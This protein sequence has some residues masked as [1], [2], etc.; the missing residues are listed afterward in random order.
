MDINV[1]IDGKEVEVNS[2]QINLK[3]TV[4]P[5]SIG[6]PSDVLDLSNWKL[7]L[8]IN[9]AKE[10]LQ[11]ELKTT[12]I[13]PYFTLNTEKTAVQF[14]AP[15]G[16]DTTSNSSYPR[17]ELRE[18]NGS[19]KASWSTT[20]GKHTLVTKQ[21]ITSFPPIKPQVV[22]AQIHD[23]KDDI[24][25]VLYDGKRGNPGAIAVRFNGKT[26]NTL[27][28]DTYQIGTI[29]ALKIEAANGYI[30]IYYNDIKKLF[31]AKVG[32]KM[33]FK[34]GCY[35]QSNVSNPACNEAPP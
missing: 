21:A 6:F 4:Q 9:I 13:E 23:D 35:T 20:S 10:I 2:L 7:T 11:P 27:L 30:N 29:F 18:M 24:I 15:C 32:S 8:P 5:S 28:D 3:T 14:R 26:Q 1:I 34:A 22:C 16:G 19:S 12:K 33:Y 25:E 17:S 31:L